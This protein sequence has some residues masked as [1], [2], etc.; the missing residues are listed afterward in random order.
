MRLISVSLRVMI[1][2]DKLVCYILATSC[3]QSMCSYSFRRWIPT[4][5]FISLWK[6]GHFERTN[7][8]CKMLL[9]SWYLAYFFKRFRSL[10]AE[11]LRS[12]GQMASKL[13]V[14]KVGGLTKKSAIRPRP[15][16]NQLARV[17]GGPG[18]NHSQ[19]LM[20]DKFAAL[21]LIDPMFSALKD[22]NPFKIL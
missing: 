15:Y 4:D 17:W 10:I 13:P 22:L 19:T 14:V 18:S 7:P 21:W 11:N 8:T 2:I 12:F 16:S 1:S 6:W 5:Y 3:I 20:A 9:A